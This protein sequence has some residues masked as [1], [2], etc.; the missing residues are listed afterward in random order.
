[1]RQFANEPPPIPARTHDD[2]VHGYGLL[3]SPRFF[4][5]TRCLSLASSYFGR[6]FG[7]GKVDYSTL[8]GM[9]ASI[10]GP[11]FTMANFA[12]VDQFSRTLTPTPCGFVGIQIVPWKILWV[13]WLDPSFGQFL[14]R[15]RFPQHH[16][17]VRGVTLQHLTKKKKS[18][19]RLWGIVLLKMGTC[20]MLRYLLCSSLTQ[21]R[22]VPS[23]QSDMVIMMT[24][25][26]NGR[27]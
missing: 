21:T 9:A 17:V 11:E 24:P 26:P 22:R 20:P 18:R 10:G 23:R 25:S 7:V 27:L 15:A 2:G 14:K 6:R 3:L 4:L 19:W 12:I 13:E 1:M 5:L 8:D 16:Q